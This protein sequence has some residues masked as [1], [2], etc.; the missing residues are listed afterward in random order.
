MKNFSSSPLE[1]PRSLWTHRALLRSLI[2]RE[3][4]GR[5]KGST[6]G[7]IWSLLTPLLLI[8]VYTF[9]FGIIFRRT[10]GASYST[11]Q[12][13]VMI[14]FAGLMIFNIFAECLNKAPSLISGRVNFVKKIIFPL[15][16]LPV[17]SLGA[18]LFQFLI[19]ATLWFV[20]YAICFGLP[21]STVWMAPLTLIPLS[22]FTMGASWLFASLGV[23]LKDLKQ[24]VG[25]LITINL[26]LSAVFYPIAAI[27]EKY[28]SLVELSP[29]TSAIEGF[30]QTVFF[31]TSLNW[32][33]YFVQLALGLL[34]AGLGFA[35]FQKTRKGFADVI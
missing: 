16:I 31:G 5:Y 1:M 27:P 8:S 20:A 30:R 2:E 21:P 32:G 28:R 19:S 23:Y 7:I 26:F 18:A 13:F 6:L 35:W 15:E 9:V 14:L 10:W 11:T 3:V 25:L 22:L 4:L 12:D 17:V 29:I 33:S 34:V 24:L